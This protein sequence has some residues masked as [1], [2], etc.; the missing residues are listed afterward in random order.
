MAHGCPVVASKTSSIGEVLGEGALLCDPHN[1][2]DMVNKVGAMISD[3]EYR[4]SFVDKGFQQIRKYT[5]AQTTKL[6][7]QTYSRFLQ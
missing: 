6:T 4:N 3:T 7:L 5:W 2:I 1:V